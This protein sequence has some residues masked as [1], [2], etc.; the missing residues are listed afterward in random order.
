MIPT[1]PREKRDEMRRLIANS[2]HWVAVDKAT[3]S[4]MI[5]M[6]PEQQGWRPTHRHYKGGLYRVIAR[7]KIEADLSPVVIYDNENGET[8]VRP[9]NDFYS[10]IDCGEGE[11]PRF[12]LRF[13][14]IPEQQEGGLHPQEPK[15][16]YPFANDKFADQN[17]PVSAREP[18]R[19]TYNGPPFDPVEYVLETLSEH[20]SAESVVACR[21]EVATL[22]A[23]LASPPSTGLV[24]ETTAVNEQIAEA[25]GEAAHWVLEKDGK[26]VAAILMRCSTMLRDHATLTAEVSRLTGELNHAQATVVAMRE[27]VAASMIRHSFATGHG[28]TLGDLLGELDWQLEE[29]RAREAKAREEEREACANIADAKR[30]WG[31]KYTADHIAAAI[32]ARSQPAPGSDHWEAGADMIKWLLDIDLEHVLIGFLLLLAGLAIASIFGMLS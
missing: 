3:L 6:I 7:G 21:K 28:D 10:S 9:E 14:M 15:P 2:D 23:S 29:V 17:L 12:V 30:G 1:L 31:V 5:D 24:L 32:R 27:S 26:E 16:D 19:A 8:W 11:I 20:A 18:G 22:S 25:E 4:E 13:D